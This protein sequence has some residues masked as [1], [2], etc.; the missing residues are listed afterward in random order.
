MAQCPACHQ[1]NP[2]SARFCASCGATLS[3]GGE[4]QPQQAW[5]PPPAYQN[6]QSAAPWVGQAAPRRRSPAGWI[7]G[8]VTALLV[9]TFGLF[10]YLGDDD[11]AVSPSSSTSSGPAPSGAKP[12]GTA[13]P[14]GTQPSGPAPSTGKSDSAAAAYFVGK[15]RCW[16]FGG[17]SCPVGWEDLQIKANGTY[18]LANNPGTWKMSGDKL[19]FDGPLAF[20]GPAEKFKDDQFEFNY[21][22]KNSGFGTYILFVKY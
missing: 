9:L 20:A 11:G 10:A 2:T 7:A 15:W 22:D 17:G 21:V 1:E 3:A 14:S 16:S 12:S 4:A 13:A 8:V 18:T 5:Q 19:V 6:P